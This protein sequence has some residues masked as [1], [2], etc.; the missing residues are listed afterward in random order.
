MSQVPTIAGAEFAWLRRSRL[1]QVCTVMFLL[2]LF[3]SVLTARVYLGEEAAHRN[4]HQ[5]EASEIFENQPDRHPHRMVHY[6]QYVFRAPPPLA[7]ID[8]GLDAY[9]GTSLFLEGHRQNAAMFSSATEGAGLVRFGSLTPA[10]I[11]QVLAPLLLILIGHDC[12]TRE[13]EA[14]TLQALLAQGV[15]LRRIALGKLSVL[16]VVSGVGVAILAG[17]ALLTTAESAGETLPALMLIATYAAY[18]ALWCLLIVATS[19]VCRRSSG[20][21]LALAA[22]WI[23][24]TV[25]VPRLAADIAAAAAP[26]ESAFSRQMTVNDALRALGDSHDPSDPNFKSFQQVVMD[27]YGVDSLDELPVNIRGLQAVEGERQ[28]AEV[29]ARFSSADQEA[30]MAQRNLIAAAGVVSPLLAIQ[31]ASQALAG[32]DLAA[33]H[34]FHNEA[35]AHRVAF[36][37]ELNMLQATDVDYALDRIK[38]IDVQAERATRVSAEAWAKLPKF[39]FDA[40]P[41]SE[42]IANASAV[43]LILGLWLAVGGGLFLRTTRGQST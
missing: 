15:S 18:L 10:F 42:R 2:L 25:V 24:T 36:V 22:L 27:E 4:E 21:F 1:A 40:A 26:L 12:I 16:L 39:D 14:S 30:R 23:V 19:C 35:E 3:L 43:L 7:A 13:R 33:Y 17:T 5:Q 9:G 29:L 28:Q 8:P 32:T 20:A 38:S 6:G 31:S 11:L 37:Q 34:R 41:A